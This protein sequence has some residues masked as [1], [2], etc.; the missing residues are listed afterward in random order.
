MT[1]AENNRILEDKARALFAKYDMTL[2]IGEWT[3]P[4]KSDSIR[5]EKK[6]RMRIHRHCHRCQTM[7]GADKL[8]AECGHTRCKKCPRSK[9]TGLKERKGKS[10]LAG[11]VVVDD[12]YLSSI[13][14][15]ALIMP[16]RKTWKDLGG[17]GSI[18]CHKCQTAFADSAVQCEACGHQRCARC[19]QDG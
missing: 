3:P 18:Q 15:D 8:C 6:I 2:E 7:F 16:Y 11:S 4:F 5:V 14:S 13:G 12:R 9:M 1:A 19:P 10:A 17:S